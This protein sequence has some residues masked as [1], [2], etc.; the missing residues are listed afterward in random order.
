MNITVLD[1][2]TLG[3][4]ISFEPLE[5]LGSLTVYESTPADKAAERISDT[6]VVTNKVKLTA[7]V[8]G[9]ANNLRL[10]CLAA[11]GYDNVDTAYC[12][13][14]GIAVCNIV[15]YSTD[16]VAQVTAAMASSLVCRLPEYT[17]FVTDGSYARSGCAN[18]LT[19]T[20]H[21]MSSLTWGVVG[22]GNIGRKVAGIAEAF[23]CRVAANRLHV[24]DGKYE[25]L[26]LD[27]LLE[28][29]D[30]VSLHCPLTD[31]TRG[32]ISRERIAKMK[33]TAI[34]INMSRGAVTDE[35][36]VA[37]AIKTGDIGGFGCDVYSSEPLSGDNP[38]ASIAGMPNV[39]LTPHMAW[40][41]HEA[42]M[43]C[44]D[45]IAENIRSFTSGG[46]RSRIV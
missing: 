3:D 13:D 39:I 37:D 40:G 17:A 33:K 22:L 30:I 36:A 31:A 46:V 34:L 44:I 10:I 23:G 11:T 12:R 15:G 19:P 42:R 5:K 4:D 6:V 16:S 24:S 38:I 26:P 45:E 35:K 27:D 32:M 25:C 41:A 21:E 28:Q 43:R 20:Y 2:A 9:K 29:S 8:L 14:H 1:K 18:R 7:E